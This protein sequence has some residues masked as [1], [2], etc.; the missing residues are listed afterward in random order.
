MREEMQQLLKTLLTIIVLSTLAVCGCSESERPS[1]E[2][3]DHPAGWVVSGHVSEA[4]ADLSSCLT[5]HGEYFKGGIAGVR[6]TECHMGNATTIHPLDW[7]T[8]VGVHHGPYTLEK[9][10]DACS[11]QY[12]HGMDGQ[13]V[14]G[15]GPS[16]SS[17]HDWPL[18]HSTDMHHSLFV[19]EGFKCTDCHQA[20][21]D[22]S[23]QC[24]TYVVI[25]N[26]QACH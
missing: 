10:H 18:G 21:W 1:V 13:G 26:C 5:C 19:T 4:Q 6:C 8:N 17:C 23:C 2:N 14:P 22:D 16:C 3:F 11:T 24:Y 9:G 25:S 12:C 7:G 15:S 20:S